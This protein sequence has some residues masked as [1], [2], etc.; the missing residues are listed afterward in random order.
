MTFFRQWLFILF[1]LIFSGATIFAATGKDESAF[2]SAT[3]QFQDGNWKRA[4]SEF[5]QFIQRYPNSG[6]VPQAVLSEAQAQFKQGKFATA[7]ILLTAH[8]ASS[9]SLAD[10]Y[11][12]WT[13]E[14]QFAKGDFTNA[15]A[16]LASLAKNFPD[17]HLRLTAAVEAAAA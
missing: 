16:T 9:G 17:S 15:A 10:N 8:A 6:Q 3:A 12:Y 7:A 13:G 4:E 5:A 11:A 2:A 14:S 1:A